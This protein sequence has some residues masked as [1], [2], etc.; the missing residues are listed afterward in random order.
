MVKVI[1]KR[2]LRSHTYCVLN[3]CRFYALIKE[4]LTLSK[5]DGGRWFIDNV[6][7][8]HDG[9][10][11]IAMDDYL[12]NANN[13]IYDEKRLVGFAKEMKKIID[14]TLSRTK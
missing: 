1:I 13:F 2:L 7:T 11:K 3:L 10:I 5:Y 9:V 14:D 4:D 8:K 6:D 12:S